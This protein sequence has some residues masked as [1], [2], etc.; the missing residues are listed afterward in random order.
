MLCI[1]MNHNSGRGRVLPGELKP[2][3]ASAHIPVRTFRTADGAL[4][5]FG[6]A[7]ALYKQPKGLF[8][9]FTRIVY[10]SKA[11]L[12]IAF[13]RFYKKLPAFRHEKTGNCVHIDDAGQNGEERIY[14][15]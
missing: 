8:L 10:K 3:S 7:A 1:G 6:T 12:S 11:R 15:M 5:P 4:H 14:I 9:L 13:V 2:S